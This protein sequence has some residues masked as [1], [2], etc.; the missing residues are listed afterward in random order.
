MR[1]L[2]AESPQGYALT[3]AGQRLLAHAERAE[4]G[5]G[6]PAEDVQA[7]RRGCRDRSASGAPDGC[8]ELPAAAGAGRDLRRQPRA[9]GADRGA[10]AGL[11]PVEARGRHG[12]RRLA[13]PRPGG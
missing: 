5:G 6:R 13:G 9:G 4:A 7:R 2:F 8:A 11:Q 12:D 3:E 1:R 10:A